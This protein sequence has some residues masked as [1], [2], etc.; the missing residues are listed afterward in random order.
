MRK[1]LFICIIFT[2]VIVLTGCNNY[3]KFKLTIKEKTWSGEI[4]EG[5]E[6]KEKT[7]EFDIVLNKKYN[8]ESNF[9]GNFTFIV[10]ELN[11]DNIIIETEEPYS[12]T[13]NGI[14]LSSSKTVF[15]IYKGK[16][17][18]IDTITMDAGAT[19]YLVLE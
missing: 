7:E 6:N 11:K 8:F 15:T 17:T 12:D 5:Y 19:Y 9:N 3:N 4:H 14:D 10:K 16:E 13:N 1:V 18:R 2:L